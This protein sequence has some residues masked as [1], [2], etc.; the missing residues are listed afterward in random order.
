[1]TKFICIQKLARVPVVRRPRCPA[2]SKSEC[3]R[4][5]Q[6]SLVPPWGMY[7]VYHGCDRAQCRV[8]ME[9]SHPVRPS[10]RF[11]LGRLHHLQDRVCRVKVG[12]QT[13]GTQKEEGG[14][15]ENRPQTSTAPRRR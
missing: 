13:V 11:D 4:P 2:N 3:V 8:F 9:V 12:A 6:D 1:M 5:Y 7:R 14:R 15:S 10:Q